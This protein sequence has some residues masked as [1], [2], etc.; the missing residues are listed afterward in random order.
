MPSQKKN[1]FIARKSFM[2]DAENSR[3]DGR[4]LKISAH[5]FIP[6]HILKPHNSAGHRGGTHITF[7][8]L[9]K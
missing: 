3:I 2:S 9:D 7:V 5:V 4:H 8:D 1:K 6:C